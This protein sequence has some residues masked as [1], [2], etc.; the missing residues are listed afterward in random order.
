MRYIDGSH[1]FI[2][3]FASCGVFPVVEAAG[4]RK[5]LGGRC[6]SDEADDGLVIAQGFSP[7]IG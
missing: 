2:A 3:H 6:V 1:F 4:D 7:P 5:S